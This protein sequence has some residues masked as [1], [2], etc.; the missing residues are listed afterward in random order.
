MTQV[1][2]D[3][4]IPRTQLIAAAGQQVFNTNWTVNALTDVVV[5][6]RLDG[7][8][9]DDETQ[10][11]STNDY[12]VTLIGGSQTVRVTFL[13]GR[14][15]DEVITI[16]RN[17]PAERLNLYINTNFVPSMLN[18]DFG[19]LTLVDQQSQMYDT[20][21]NPGYNVS[22]TIDAKD[23]ILPILS[24]YEAWRMNA[25]GT[26]IEPVI[27]P[28]G[29][30]APQIGSFVTVSDERSDLPNSFPLFDLGN[31]STGGMGIPAG[32]TAQRVNPTAPNIGLRFNTDIGII[33]AFI[34]GVWVEIPSSSAGLF[35]PLAGGTMTG[36]I[37]MDSNEINNLPLPSLAAQ[38]ATKGYVDGIAFNIHPAANYGTTANLAGYTY[39]NGVSGV[40]ATLTAGSN[41]A[42]SV[43]GSSPTLNNRILVKNQT[44]QAQNGIYVLSTVGDGSTAA[45]LTRATD[46]DTSDDMQAGDEVAVVDGATLAGSKWMMTQT[47][48]ITIGTT[49]IT[50]INISVPQNVVTLDGA[51][52]ITGAK[53]FDANVVLG[54]NSTLTLNGTIAIDEILDEDNM[55]SDS[56]TAVPTQQSVKAYIDSEVGASGGLKSIQ[57]FTSNGT[58]TR[59]SGINK[60]LVEAA[61]G[62]GGGGYAAAGVTAGA[63]GS[64]GGGGSYSRLLLD[65]SAIPSVAVV[66]GAAGAGGIGSTAT[67]ATAGGT[68]TFGAHITCP[69]GNAGSQ[70]NSGTGANSVAGA[71]P[72]S[73]STGGD[74]NIPGTAGGNTIRV[75]QTTFSSGVGGFSKLGHGGFG[76]ATGTGATWSGGTPSGYG[77]GGGGAGAYNSVNQNGGNGSAGIVIVYEFT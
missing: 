16:V 64:G 63:S 21:V 4:I 32:T 17:T 33:E 65:V 56:A 36:N 20:V 19:I 66:I 57:I 68:T 34:G 52:T 47:A 22:A 29:G 42:F 74:I 31:A 25:A 58:W 1:I 54:N 8:E 43:D 14:T 48:A 6:A 11:V 71:M 59:P 72:S 69:G 2:I 50:W 70:T 77:G 27:I 26:A 62:G 73:A 39:D 41:G 53:T 60:I 12:N 67:N 61:G 49:A 24:A 38:P 18:N 40:G 10:V 5:Y 23:K 7:V 55:V 46:Y 30:F 35:L 51:Q 37:D 45:V 75:N 3:D 15:L 9:A 13:V 44:T 28:D 76:N